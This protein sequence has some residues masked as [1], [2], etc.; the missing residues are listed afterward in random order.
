MYRIA[1][2]TP[3]P[4]LGGEQAI[5]WDTPATFAVVTDMIAEATWE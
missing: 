2:F 4:G 3:S 5:T 1:G